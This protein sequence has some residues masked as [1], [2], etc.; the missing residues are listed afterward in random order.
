VSGLRASPLSQFVA[1]IK[2]GG[3]DFRMNSPDFEDKRRGLSAIRIQIHPEFIVVCFAVLQNRRKEGCMTTVQRVGE[4][5]G[6][7]LDLGNRTL[8]ET[9]EVAL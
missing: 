6:R 5:P 7:A 8:R 4:A 9:E 1:A 3:D 2:A